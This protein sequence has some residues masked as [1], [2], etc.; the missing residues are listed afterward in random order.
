VQEEA[1]LSGVEVVASLGHQTVEFRWQGNHYVR[2]EAYFLMITTGNTRYQE[3]ERQFKRQWLSW[4]NALSRLTYEAEQEWLK[5]ARR[6]WASQL[7][8]RPRSESRRDLGKP[9]D[10]DTG[11][12]L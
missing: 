8:G 4:D 9:Q 7:K 6:V 1:G 11:S 5:R 3:P 2:D 12:H 10:E